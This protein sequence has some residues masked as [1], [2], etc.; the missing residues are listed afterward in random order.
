MMD[1]RWASTNG[2]DQVA[3]LLQG[4]SNTDGTCETS[5]EQT[6]EVAFKGR[7]RTETSKT[8]QE[9]QVHR[10]DCAYLVV[11]SCVVRTLRSE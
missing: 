11:E 10:G 8:S 6:A 3:L 5:N 7:K 1:L 4:C 9:I 2:K